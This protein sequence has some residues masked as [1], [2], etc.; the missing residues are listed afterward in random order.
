M[1]VD[2]AD[3]QGINQLDVVKHGMGV[4]GQDPI[5]AIAN[6][7]IYVY[8]CLEY[9]D[10]AGAIHAMQDLFTPEHGGNPWDG[11]TIE[12]ILGDLLPSSDTTDIAYEQALKILKIQRE[13]ETKD[14]D[15]GCQ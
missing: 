1:N 2:F 8:I 12:H 14:T 11:Y 15:Q 3:T 13:K 5:I 6:T 7:L 4:P 9:G 10:A